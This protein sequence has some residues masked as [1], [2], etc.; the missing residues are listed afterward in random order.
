MEISQ[1]H[2]SCSGSCLPETRS[3]FHVHDRNNPELI[4]LFQVDDTKW[5]PGAEMA[6][7][8]RIKLSER[9]GMSRN[10]P[11]QPFDLPK[12]SFTQLLIDGGIIS[13]ALTEFG[14]SFRMK[15][16]PHRER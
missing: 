12:E 4:W 1:F 3:A 13:H 10:L 16:N 7:G 15:N 14:V 8:R 11:D 5:K 9:L 6:S 2:L